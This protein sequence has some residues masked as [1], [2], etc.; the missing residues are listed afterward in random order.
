MKKLLTLLFAIAGLSSFA[1]TDWKLSGNSV[2][3]DS[4]LGTN[5]GYDLIFET[6]NM[7][8]FRLTDDG[9]MG[10][11]IASPEYKFDILGEMR[12]DGVL[13]LPQLTPLQSDEKTFL[14]V[15]EGGKVKGMTLRGGGGGDPGLLHQLYMRD[16]NPFTDG[17]GNITAYPAPVWAS[18]AGATEQESRLYTGSVCPAYVGIGLNDPQFNLH[19]AGKA[20]ISRLGLYADPNSNTVL[21]MAV[22]NSSTDGIN[23]DFNSINDNRV[24][25]KMN[26]PQNNDKLIQLNNT[27]SGTAVMELNAG[28]ELTLRP[29]MPTAKAISIKDASNADVFRFSTDGVMWSTEVNVALKQDFPDYV[30][31]KDYELMSLNELREYLK[32][33]QHLPNVPAAGEV[34]EKGLNLGEMQVIQMEKIEENTLYILQLEERLQ[35]LEE[36]NV[37]MAKLIEELQNK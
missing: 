34:K 30:F 23:I 24:A 26:A 5:N 15:D 13:M 6:A 19:V 22:V 20:K 16:C 9:K 8:R 32:E 28:G 3:S 1:Q 4:K 18:S 27:T 33:N 2:S 36:Q 11:G 35:K 12:L 37:Q 10:V 7:E 17:Q 21:N 29:S 14:F 25:L 31:D